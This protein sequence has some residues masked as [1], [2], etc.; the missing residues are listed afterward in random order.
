MASAS[1]WHATTVPVAL[2]ERDGEHGQLVVKHL[3]QTASGKVY[4]IWIERHDVLAP[5]D[6]LFEPTSNGDATV[7]VPGSLRGAQAVLVTAE[8]SGGASVPSMAPL[9][10]A[11]LAA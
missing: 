10:T 8:R 9:I 11:T 4:E 6:A 2:L 1:V 3:P 5:T 7:D